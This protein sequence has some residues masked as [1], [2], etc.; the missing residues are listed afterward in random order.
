MSIEELLTCRCKKQYSIEPHGSKN[1]HALYF[2]RCKHKHGFNVLKISE[3][4]RQD[5]L[6]GIVEALN[7]AS[8]VGF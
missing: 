8:S 3:C 2:G 5:I 4:G 7:T 6:D 1:E